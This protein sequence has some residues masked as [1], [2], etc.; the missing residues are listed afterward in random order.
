MPPL[1]P[2]AAAAAMAAAILLAAC[3][4][5]PPDHHPFAE[6]L[7]PREPKP[8]A[9]SRVA[10][11]KPFGDAPGALIA[12][13]EPNSW[14]LP[15][16]AMLERLRPDQSGI[17]LQINA[18]AAHPLAGIF[19]TSFGAGGIAAY[20]AMSMPM[21][22]PTS[23]SAASRQDHASTSSS[24]VRK[25]ALAQFADATAASGAAAAAMGRGLRDGRSRCRWRPR[26]P[27]LPLRRA[28][29]CFG[30]RRRRRLRR[31]RGG[32]RVGG[33]RRVRGG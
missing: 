25:A 20:A 29:L 1:R 9:A 33:Q 12:P 3:G 24:M 2:A 31:R 16:P 18:D 15:P 23:F 7:P 17:D 14:P 28:L 21:G 5:D 19:S 30:Q 32:V 22:C 27:R 10:P 6:K 8:P 13:L 26:H 4:E 11:L